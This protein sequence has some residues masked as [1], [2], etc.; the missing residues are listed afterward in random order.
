MAECNPNG[1]DDYSQFKTNKDKWQ[2]NLVLTLI[3]SKTE[4]RWHCFS[5]TVYKLFG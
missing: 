3:N 5:K 4:N 2:K 1:K